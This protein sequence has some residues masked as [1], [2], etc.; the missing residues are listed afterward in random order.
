[1]PR[2]TKPAVEIRPPLSFCGSKIDD[3]YRRKKSVDLCATARGASV[4]VGHFHADEQFGIDDRGQGRGLVR[5]TPRPVGGGALEREDRARVDYDARGS[6]GSGSAA[7]IRSSEEANSGSGSAASRQRR[8]ASTMVP[9][10]FP[11]A[12][13]KRATATPFCSMMNDSPR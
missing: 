11:R 10:R 9:A 7:P 1:M 13:I 4:T 5:K 6:P 8:S 3:G 2:P 12:G